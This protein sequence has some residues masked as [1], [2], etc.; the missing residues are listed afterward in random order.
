MLAGQ[1]DLAVR[2]RSR[3]V[4]MRTTASQPPSGLLD[5][6]DRTALAQDYLDIRGARVHNL[7]N[8]D[9]RLPHNQLTVVTGVSG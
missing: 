4:T 8:I 9:L 1:W 7:K 5:P 6:I 2:H 3:V